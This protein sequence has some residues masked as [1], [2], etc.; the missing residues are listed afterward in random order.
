M[1]VV[2]VNGGY[3]RKPFESSFLPRPTYSSLFIDI[4]NTDPQPDEYWR[5]DYTTKKFVAPEGNINDINS[6]YTKRLKWNDVRN[7]RQ[8][9]L[10]ESD[11]TQMPDSALPW[12]EKL[13][14]RKY[15]QELRDIPQKYAN[16]N[17]VFV[18]FPPR[19]T[20]I[21]QRTFLQR[22]IFVFNRVFRGK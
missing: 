7:Q 10:M 8:I 9:F 4:T 12:R 15:R 17:P 2:E 5:Y 6:E 19:P 18:V 1:L 3:C 13:A 16:E 22:L 21:I 20:H 11:W 14:W